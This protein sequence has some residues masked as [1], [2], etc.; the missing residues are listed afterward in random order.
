MLT[1]RKAAALLVV[2]VTV[3][4]AL[5]VNGLSAVDRQDLCFDS[6]VNQCGGQEDA[7]IGNT[8]ADSD[9]KFLDFILDVS[10]SEVEGEVT[11]EY[12]D[13]SSTGFTDVND[14]AGINYFNPGSDTDSLYVSS[15][16]FFGVDEGESTTISIDGEEHTFEFLNA[17]PPNAGEVEV[18][19]SSETVSVRESVTVSGE[20]VQIAGFRSNTYATN[21]TLEDG[22]STDINGDTLYLGSVFGGGTIYYEINGN[23]GNAE[24]GDILFVGGD[25]IEVAEVAPFGD[26]SGQVE[27]SNLDDTV[28]EWRVDFNVAPELESPEGFNEYRA[29]WEGSDGR[30]EYSP[31]MFFSVDRTQNLP[32]DDFVVVDDQYVYSPY[33]TS[34]VTVGSDIELY[35]WQDENDEVTAELYNAA[36]DNQVDSKTVSGWNGNQGISF[37]TAG[38]DLMSQ[39]GTQYSFYFKIRQTSDSLERTTKEYTVDTSGTATNPAP[40]IQSVEAYSGEQNSWVPLENIEFGA[41]EGVR[42]NVTDA[43]N[44]N[45]QVNLTMWNEEENESLLLAASDAK[46]SFDS[47]S[48][49]G[50]LYYWND[51]DLKNNSFGGTY[52]A[53]VNA[54]DFDNEVSSSYTWDYSYDLATD[55]VKHQPKEG[56]VFD[57]RDVKFNFSVDGNQGDV[58]VFVDGVQE[59]VWSYDGDFNETFSY[60]QT[61]TENGEYN[62]SVKY[63]GLDASEK[64][65]N[66][67]TFQVNATLD[68]YIENVSPDPG[69][70][71][72]GLFPVDVQYEFEVSGESGTVNLYQNGNVVQSYNHP[73]SKNRT[74]TVDQQFSSEQNVTW[75]VEFVPDDTG[76]QLTSNTQEFEITR[77]TLDTYLENISPDPGE[78]IINNFPFDVGYEFEVSGENGTVNLYQDGGVIQSFDHERGNNTTYTFDQEVTS[79]DNK[80]WYV[81][82]VPDQYGNQLSSSPQEFEVTSP[83][84]IENVTVSYNES[85]DEP[86]IITRLSGNDIV[87][88]NNPDGDTAVFN[89]T[90]WVLENV[91]TVYNDTLVVEDSQG[92]TT[93]IGVNYSITDY[94]VRQEND[95]DT[96]LDKQ[97]LN[98]TVRHESGQGS[99]RNIYFKTLFENIPSVQRTGSLSQL[100]ELSSSSSDEHVV[101]SEVDYISE[102]NQSFAPDSVVAGEDPQIRF[103]ENWTNT[104]SY[105]SLNQLNKSFVLPASVTD[106]VNLSVDGTDYSDTGL[107]NFTGGANPVVDFA[108]NESVASGQSLSINIFYNESGVSVVENTPNQQDATVFEDVPFT[109]TDFVENDASIEFSEVEVPVTIFSDARNGSTNVVDEFGRT[110]DVTR[111]ETDEIMFTVQDLE[112]GENRRIDTTFYVENLSIDQANYTV[113]SGKQVQHYELNMSTRGQTNFRNLDSFQNVSNPQQVTTV[114]LFVDGSEVTNDPDY[115]FDFVDDDGDGL[116]ETAEWVVPSIDDR[117][118][119]DVRVTRGQPLNTSVANVIQN[120]PVE[121]GKFIRWRKGVKV[122]NPNN[123][124]TEFSRKLRVPQRASN[125]FLEGELVSKRVDSQGTYV[126]YNNT[127]GAQSNLTVYLE[128]ETPSIE[129]RVQ[130]SRPDIYWVDKKN[131][132]FINVTFINELPLQ[133]EQARESV[134]ILEGWNLETSSRGEVL[135]TRNNVSGLY[136]FTVPTVN[137]SSTR[138]AS[139]RYEVPVANA[140]YLG[141]RNISNGNKLSSWEIEVLSPTSLTDVRFETDRFSCVQARTA[142]KVDENKSLEIACGNEEGVLEDE[143]QIRFDNLQSGDT[144]R[145]AVEHRPYNA[146]VTNTRLLVNTLAQNTLWVALGGLFIVVVAGFRREIVETLKNLVNVN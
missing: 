143:T 4:A 136:N 62:W 59:K 105:T 114:Q 121:E 133:V 46:D 95:A 12:K 67:T 96:D 100:T 92:R 8:D 140:S 35:M 24:E 6:P 135:D 74:Y 144:F 66:N 7:E 32:Y 131:T 63:L 72:N 130:Q 34:D 3:V 65:T 48:S 102:V 55:V 30:T 23:G 44:D 42:A 124:D 93:S 127:V 119:Y 138:E 64:F 57:T 142:Y 115:D 71:F 126:P 41:L 25:E 49:S 29:R 80:T 120:K 19:G 69:E 51:Q 90:H 39:Q 122:S 141:K 87:S 26:G 85:V 75:Y 117:Q 109:E 103:E 116:Q 128:F 113:T 76:N 37:S 91:S 1:R 54:T 73:R 11:L 94:G 14:A 5:S 134:D 2:M 60:N 97:F 86:R 78:I 43:N 21:F 101:W 112:A 84:Y 38:S 98:Q 61:F 118:D 81:E 40:V 129:T 31:S 53:F 13:S 17:I 22:D 9:G 16:D 28:T 77:P 110:L 27:F 125:L 70:V 82:F 106:L 47:Y 111:T 56:Q 50:N 83:E 33:T 79:P 10:D 132:A 137:A 145:I 99:S 123:F 20:T 68:T 107:V 104:E 139:I 18:D 58:S 52:N 36:N 108:W 45:L 89:S 15:S 146:V 88:T